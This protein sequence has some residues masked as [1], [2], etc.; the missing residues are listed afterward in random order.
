MVSL[1][2]Q[3]TKGSYV[4]KSGVLDPD[5]H[6]LCLLALLME[7]SIYSLFI[8]VGLLLLLLLFIVV[9]YC[10]CLL[11]LGVTFI[12]WSHCVPIRCVGCL[13]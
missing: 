1:S 10:C 13:Y 3:I 2:D 6:Y 8:I 12:M 9:V 5:A 7:V 4:I 11:L